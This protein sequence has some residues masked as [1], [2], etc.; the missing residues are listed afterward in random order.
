MLDRAGE[1]GRRPEIER[2]IAFIVDRLVRDPRGWGD[3]VRD[4]RHAKLTEYHGRHDNFLAVYA[5]HER[6]PMVFLSQLT[7]LEGNPLYGETFDA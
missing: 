5:V 3:P 4:L 2:S 1:I 6:V 7:P